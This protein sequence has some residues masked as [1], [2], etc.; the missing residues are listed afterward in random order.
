MNVG[1]VAVPEE[2]TGEGSAGN[3]RAAASIPARSLAVGR[4]VSR[5]GVPDREIA[6]PKNARPGTGENE[7]LHDGI[8]VA[9]AGCSAPIGPD[10]FSVPRT[11]NTRVR[12]EILSESASFH[13]SDSVIVQEFVSDGSRAGAAA[14][15]RII[16]RAKRNESLMRDYSGWFCHFA[17]IIPFAGAIFWFLPQ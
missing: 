5:A 7:T 10:V 13:K 11:E 9:G 12:M 1:S 4:F 16:E 8:V 14:N 15:R 3:S 6:P 17:R 2:S